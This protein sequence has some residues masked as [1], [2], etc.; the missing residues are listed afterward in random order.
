MNFGTNNLNYPQ[1]NTQLNFGTMNNNQAFN[2]NAYGLNT[3][4]ATNN[5]NMNTGANIQISQPNTSNS[6]FDEP[7]SVQETQK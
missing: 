4:F 3:L 6:F 5:I 1:Q 7:S 2:T